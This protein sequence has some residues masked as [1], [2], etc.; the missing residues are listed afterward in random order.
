MLDEVA[1]D[2]ITYAFHEPLHE[3]KKWQKKFE[4]P[5]CFQ[6]LVLKESTNLYSDHNRE[7]WS[8]RQ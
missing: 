3:K 4:Y 1:L 8:S 2:H 6:V 5:T 7:T